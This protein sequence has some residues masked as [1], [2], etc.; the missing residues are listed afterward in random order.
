MIVSTDNNNNNNTDGPHYVNKYAGIETSIEPIPVPIAKMVAPGP[1][2]HPA[3]AHANAFFPAE[4][5][6]VVPSA[7]TNMVQNMG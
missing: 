7:E 6:P 4:F 3:P 5:F 1:I 2:P